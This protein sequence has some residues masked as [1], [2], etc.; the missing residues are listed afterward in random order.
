MEINHRTISLV[1]YGTDRDWLDQLPQRGWLCVLVV[2][3]KRRTYAEEVVAKLL[4]RDVA[5][6]CAVGAAGE[7]VHDVLDEEIGIREVE[8]LYLPPHNVVTTWHDEIEECLWFALFT[9]HDGAV[10]LDHVAVLDL[11]QGAALPRIQAY[12]ETLAA[13]PNE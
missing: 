6:V 10:L 8:A 11:T 9:A 4:L 13:G 7:W 5:W 3:E 12:L 1:E 2:E